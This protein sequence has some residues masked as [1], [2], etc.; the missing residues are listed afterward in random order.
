MALP[1]DWQSVKT[2]EGK[3]YFWNQSTG[4]TSWTRP[5]KS[6]HR[7]SSPPQRK[8]PLSPEL[9]PAPGDDLDLD[10]PVTSTQDGASGLAESYAEEVP[11]RTKPVS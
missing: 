1:R 5:V 3:T 9:Y 4:E 10:G 2:P 6:E 8:A 11:P 7:V